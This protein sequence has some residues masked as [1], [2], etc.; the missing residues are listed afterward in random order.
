MFEAMPLTD[1]R[2]RV[3]RS[4]SSASLK[5]V[6]ASPV[7]SVSATIWTSGTAVTMPPPFDGRG[8]IGRRHRCLKH[9]L[10]FLASIRE[11]R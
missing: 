2:D 5:I 7:G 6:F 11:R 8:Q 9:D 3:A 1:V 10:A 4:E